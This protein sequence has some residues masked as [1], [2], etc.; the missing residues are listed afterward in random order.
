MA[1]DKLPNQYTLT[2]GVKGRLIL[3]VALRAQ[4][5]LHEGDKVI[6]RVKPDGI[7][8]LERL[9]E[10]ATRCQGI[11][12]HVAPD[13]ILVQELLEERRVDGEKE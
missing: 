10:R 6:L 12:A 5:P 11:F 2:I 13:E 8:E 1:K 4:I 9:Y 7:I 3:P